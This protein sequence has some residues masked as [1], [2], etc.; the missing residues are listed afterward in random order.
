LVIGFWNLRF[1]CN[2]VLEIW[3]FGFQKKSRKQR[4][5]CGSGFPASPERERWRAGSR[6]SNNFYAYYDFNDLPITLIAMEGD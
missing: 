2:L 4:F 3:D 1:I 6:D 5:Y